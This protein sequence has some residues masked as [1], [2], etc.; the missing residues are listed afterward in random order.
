MPNR[1]MR[2]WLV[3]RRV[4]DAQKQVWNWMR[5][6]RI[7]LEQSRQTVCFMFLSILPFCHSLFISSF[8]ICQITSHLHLFNV[9]VLCFCCFVPFAAAST[10]RH[11][12][13]HLQVVTKFPSIKLYPHLQSPTFF[14]NSTQFTFSNMLLFIIE[15]W[16]GRHKLVKTAQLRVPARS[17]GD[18]SVCLTV[19]PRSTFPRAETSRVHQSNMAASAQH[20]AQVLHGKRSEVYLSGLHFNL[21]VSHFLE[22]YCLN[23]CKKTR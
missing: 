5:D 3:R 8:L 23:G 13:I 14:P 9:G 21:L 22:I 2:L 15:V 17:T 6:N 16:W 7:K 10:C 19:C 18:E 20:S 1:K 11:H 4:L 12:I